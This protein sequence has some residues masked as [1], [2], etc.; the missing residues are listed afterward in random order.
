MLGRFG[1]QPDMQTVSGGRPCGMHIVKVRRAIFVRKK[2]AK[3][4]RLSDLLDFL[5]N[6]KEDGIL[7]F[8]IFRK[9]SKAKSPAPLR[10]TF[11][12]DG[13]NYRQNVR[14][15]CVCFSYR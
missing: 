14:K 3:V 2:V 7:K 11:G 9:F 12:E 10:W 6:A 5:A 8:A 15:I 13:K 1:L 4:A